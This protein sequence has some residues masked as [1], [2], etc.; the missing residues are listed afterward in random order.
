MF[1]SQFEVGQVHLPAE[2]VAPTV[3]WDLVR[4]YFTELQKTSDATASHVDLDAILSGDPEALNIKANIETETQNNSKDNTPGGD[5]DASAAE[6]A[7]DKQPKEKRERIGI[8]ARLDRARSYALRLDTTTSSS[9]GGHDIIYRRS[10][11]IQG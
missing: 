3:D 8:S 11:E 7:D 5:N 4:K 9:P 10:E 6:S 2:L 1:C